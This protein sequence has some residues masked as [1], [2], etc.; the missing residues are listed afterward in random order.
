MHTEYRGAENI[1]PTGIQ[2]SGKKS[3]VKYLNNNQLNITESEFTGVNQLIAFNPFVFKG[4]VTSKSDLRTFT[5]DNKDN[6][7]FSVDMIDK[8]GSEITVTFFGDAATTY[9]SQLDV[10]AVYVMRNGSSNSKPC[11]SV[12]MINSKFSKKY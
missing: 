7:V 3:L 2:S 6:T 12:R 8:E 11:G 1:P 4:R 9:H 10:N 5:K